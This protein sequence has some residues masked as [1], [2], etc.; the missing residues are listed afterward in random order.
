MSYRYASIPAFFDDIN[1]EA[2]FYHASS[3]LQ[4]DGNIKLLY[5]RGMNVKSQ[6]GLNQLVVDKSAL[7][8]SHVLF[9][10]VSGR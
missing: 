6:Y 3:L 9:G 1:F 4:V 7:L 8:I 5:K 2:Y 10:V